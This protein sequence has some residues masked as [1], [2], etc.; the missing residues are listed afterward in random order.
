M[1]TV[2]TALASVGVAVAVAAAI[3][4]TGGAF[5]LAQCQLTANEVAR[6]QARGDAAAV[7]RAS[8]DAPTGARVRVSERDGV[9]HVTVTLEVGM[10][11][12]RVPVETSARVIAEARR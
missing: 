11:P 4:V 8:A 10:G 12:V 9:A 7:A 1:V 3:G 5:R 6:Q 2:E